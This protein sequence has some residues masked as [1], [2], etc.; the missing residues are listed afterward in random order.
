MIDATIT[1]V[2]SGLFTELAIRLS[3]EFTKV[4]TFTPWWAEFPTLN[5]RAVGSGI[6]EIE[7]IED[8]Y[9]DEVFDTTDLYAFPDIF[10]AGEQRL[11]QRLNKPVWGSCTG[12]SLET[13]RI[14]FRNLQKEMGMPVP[15]S[16]EVTGW[17]ALVDHIKNNGHCFLKTT[18]K[19]RGTMETKEIFD[20]EQAEYWLW[21]LRVRLGCG[22]EHVVFL[23]E[24]P[25]ESSF[26]TGIDTYC[27]DGQ[28][29]KTPMQG[30]E[31]KGKLIL[32]SAQTKS[33]TPKPLDDALSMLSA[34]LKRR[35]YRN[36]LSAEFRKNILTDFCARAPNPG[37]GVE[38]EMISNIGAIIYAGSKG[39]L[40]EPE[41]EFEFGIQA[42]I[43]HDDDKEIWKQFRIA[44]ELRRWVKLMEFC[45][46]DGKC[47]IIP[48]PPYGEKIGWLIGVG[49]SIEEASNHLQENAKALKEYPFDIKI[50]ALEEAVKQAREMESEGMEFTDQPIPEPGKLLA[51][52]S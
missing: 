35:K 12:D 29:P 30:I 2:D 33:N 40:I 28:F 49:N 8:P 47:Q 27:V 42:A 11:V 38:M 14:W 22:A 9:L 1:V 51:E 37:I 3:R 4:R 39:E 16:V 41:Y 46:N 7:W 20:Y 32:S 10:R 48:R 21:N 25:I 36:F 18:S 13:R 31:V 50:D 43:F 5:D 34:E 15:E 17:T 44:P 19:I 24:Q 26:E 23:L 52:P 45:E 6:G